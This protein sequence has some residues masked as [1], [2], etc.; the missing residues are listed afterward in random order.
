VWPV[1]IVSESHVILTSGSEEELPPPPL[2]PEPLTASN[3]TVILL[4]YSS[5]P[6][7]RKNLPSEFNIKLSTS[8]SY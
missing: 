2:P 8:G 7:T 1:E 5:T 3:L 4:V 6:R